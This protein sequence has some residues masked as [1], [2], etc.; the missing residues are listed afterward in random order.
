ME[1]REY[2]MR[3]LARVAFRALQPTIEK[4][5]TE[6]WTAKSIYERHAEKLTAISYPQF[7]RYCRSLKEAA[8]PQATIPSKTEGTPR[9]KGFA[10]HTGIADP[11]LIRKLTSKG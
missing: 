8:Q 4:E 9:G 10:S 11:D 3:G 7:A 2:P 5:L 6:G 1:R